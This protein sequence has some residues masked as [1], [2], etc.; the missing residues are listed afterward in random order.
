MR[1]IVFI[2]LFLSVPPVALFSKSGARCR[3]DSRPIT[4]RKADYERV[5]QYPSG[6]S[7]SNTKQ[8]ADM[9]ETEGRKFAVD[10]SPLCDFKR[11]TERLTGDITPLTGRWMSNR[12]SGSF[13]GRVVREAPAHHCRRG[14]EATWVIRDGKLYLKEVRL[15]TADQAFYPS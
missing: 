9:I 5:L 13:S 10:Y 15:R 11:I 3:V 14:F 2:L 12:S 4:E 6:F 7:D 1:R 8:A